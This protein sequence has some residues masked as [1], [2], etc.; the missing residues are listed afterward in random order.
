M[1]G[2][3]TETLSP[4]PPVPGSG[5]EL[6]RFARLQRKLAPLFRRIAADQRAPQTVVVVPSLSLDAEELAKIPGAH[7]YEERL[8]CMLMLLRMPRTRLVFVT[9]QQVPN[10]IIDYY[11]HL[12]PGVPLRHARGRL[13]L[14]SCHDAS[15]MP[16]TQ[17]ILD[18]P[19][20]VG[21]IRAAIPDPEAAHLT[22]FN[23]T[24]LER[25]LAVRL[26]IPLYGNDPKLNYLGTKSG[27]RQVFREAGVPVPDGFEDLRDEGDIAEALAGLKR[28]HPGL[29]RAVIKLNEGFSGE[30]NAVFSFE[31]APEGRELERWVRRELPRRTRF[32]A[33]GESWEHFLGKFGEMG[34]IV[35]C[36]VEGEEVRSPS[37][38]C[39]INPAGEASIVSTHDQ[40][41]GGPSGQIFLGSTFPAD[42]AYSR[43]IKEAGERVGEV[44]KKRGAL[45][46]FAIDFIS[47]RR[48]GSWEHVAIEINLRK[49]GTT[50]PYLILR[51]L[52]DGAYDPEDG[53]YCTPTGQPCYYYASDNI[54]SPAYR[55][56]TPDDLVDIAVENGLHF[57]AASQQGVV[58][59]LIGAL[60]QYGK[61][62]AVCIG[63]SHESA[64]RLYLDTVE[65]LDREARR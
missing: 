55:G 38:Q 30:G 20:L 23:S 43:D 5:E 45:G 48:E 41:L 7:H 19:R 15:D 31:G 10:A 65:V 60:S 44:L 27:G 42:A 50:H 12:L 59:H 21:R 14:L 39:R 13:T 34:G 56:L 3:G 63:D 4:A 35:E 54:Q 17:K 1:S 32:E 53:L 28:R 51:F 6:A 2:E 29:R 46:R 47:V 49:G 16:L 22:C 62:G 25:T 24:H 37:V 57:D 36:W 11:L 58:F 8:L 18:R 33:R 52:T 64:R 61:L 9:S 40:V 26:G